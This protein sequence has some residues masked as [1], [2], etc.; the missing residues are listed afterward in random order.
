MVSLSNWPP[1][2][3][4]EE[5]QVTHEWVGSMNASAWRTAFVVACVTLSRSIFTV[6]QM[7]LIAGTSTGDGQVVNYRIQH[8][9][10]TFVLNAE[11][12]VT[13]MISLFRTR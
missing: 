2:V 10:N 5:G 13:V 6:V 11:P 12:Q 7:P 4:A 9:L 8:R 3:N 1:R